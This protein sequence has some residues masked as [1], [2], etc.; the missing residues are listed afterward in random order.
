MPTHHSARNPLDLLHGFSQWVSDNW[1]EILIA[2]TAGIV[3]YAVLG[4]INS[5]AQRLLRRGAETAPVMGVF[6]EALSRTMHMFMMLVAARLVVGYADPTPALLRTIGFLFTVMTALQVAIWLRAIAIG[7]IQLRSD[8]ELGGN[9][10]LANASGLI[11]ALVTVAIFA[12]AVVVVLDNLGVNVTALVAGL[13]IGGIAI[14]LAAQ[15][16]FSDL[17]A[18]LS[19]IFDKPFQVGETINFGSQTG[20][21]ERIGLKSTRLR[22]V[23]GERMIVSNAQLLNK[24][25]VSYAQLVRRRILFAVGLIYQTTPE[26][27]A[28]LPELLRDIVTRHGGTF[29][30]AGFVGFGASSLD[31]ELEFDVMSSDWD[32]VFVTRH[33]I[34]LAILD[35]FAERGLEFAYPTQTT[36]T[37]AP[38][39]RMI[40]PYPES[41][42]R[43]GSQLSSE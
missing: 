4:I 10:T 40:M 41:R 33:E 32:E 37:A 9:D 43:P 12:I 2:I 26:A 13:G 24:E 6:A 22:V 39:G 36:F 38:D 15:G 3:I 25:I 18:S 27:C 23:T 5:I 14:G 8:P 29:I 21:V 42:R 28:A 30:R 11:K 16:I 1:V 34:G 35:A 17:F 19:I 31:F 20:T 7:L